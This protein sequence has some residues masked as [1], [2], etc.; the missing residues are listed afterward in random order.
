[1]LRPGSAPSILKPS[2]QPDDHTLCLAYLERHVRTDYHISP[3]H[4]PY[5]HTPAT[6]AITYRTKSSSPK[7]SLTRMTPGR[8]RMSVGNT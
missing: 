2:H 4:R 1:M 8:K 5:V 7:S 3:T 6:I